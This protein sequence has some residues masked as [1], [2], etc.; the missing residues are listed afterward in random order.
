M[1]VDPDLPINKKKKLIFVGI[2][3]VTDEKQHPGSQIR[4]RK[5]VV[6]IPGSGFGDT[7]GTMSRIHNTGT[8]VRI[9]HDEI[10]V[11]ALTETS[12]FDCYRSFRIRAWI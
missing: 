8:G 2:L 11:H 12:Y 4:I 6:R 7:K 1:C 9:L 3:S 10:P 5:S